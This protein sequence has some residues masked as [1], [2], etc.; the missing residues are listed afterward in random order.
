[1]PVLGYLDDLVIVPAGIALALRLIPT[2]V[3]Q[4]ARQAAA[5][6]SGRTGWLGW[7]G[8]GFIVIVWLALLFLLL[9]R[10]WLLAWVHGLGSR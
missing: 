3:M 9:R 6:G 7:L 4:E 2:G 8:A 1:V 10:L 5:D